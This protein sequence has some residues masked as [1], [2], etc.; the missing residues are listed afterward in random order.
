MGSPPPP[1]N[2]IVPAA[3]VQAPPAPAALRFAAVKP[4][5]QRRGLMPNPWSGPWR[6]EGQAGSQTDR[7]TDGRE[8]AAPPCNPRRAGGCLRKASLYAYVCVC[9]RVYVC[10]AVF[11]ETESSF[12]RKSRSRLARAVVHAGRGSR[13]QPFPS[14]GSVSR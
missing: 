7:Q 10:A 5:P 14:S 1:P 6:C 13:G 3:G 9:V 12:V 4:V 11:Q 8:A 2:L